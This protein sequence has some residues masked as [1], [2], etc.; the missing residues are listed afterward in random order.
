MDIQRSGRRCLL[1][2]CARRHRARVERGLTSH[3]QVRG[4]ILFGAFPRYIS[5]WAAPLVLH[6]PM[7]KSNEK[8]CLSSAAAEESLSSLVRAAAAGVT[9]RWELF[10]DI[11]KV[12]D[13]GHPDPSDRGAPGFGA[14]LGCDI[15]RL[16]EASRRAPSLSRAPIEL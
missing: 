8:G 1:D 15:E 9:P 6:E 12:G 13:A 14:R 2:R 7:R 16:C 11:L 5:S 3:P 4:D 10:A